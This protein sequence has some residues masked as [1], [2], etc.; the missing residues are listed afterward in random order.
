MAAAL[1]R[2]HIRMQARCCGGFC[3]LPASYDEV[4]CHVRSATSREW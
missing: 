4:R 3:G 1:A 2:A